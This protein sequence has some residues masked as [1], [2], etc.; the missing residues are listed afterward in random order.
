MIDAS[1]IN[2][3]KTEQAKFAREEAMAQAE[4]EQNIALAW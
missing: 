4:P 1:L 2:F 3:V